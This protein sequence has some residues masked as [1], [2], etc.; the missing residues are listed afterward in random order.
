[1]GTGL[2][3]L[4]CHFMCI[5]LFVVLLYYS[6]D[7][8]RVYSDIP[9]FI[10]ELVICVLFLK[11]VLLEVCQFYWSYQM[12]YWY[13]LL[14]FCFQFHWFSAPV[15]IIFFLLIT[16]VYFALLFWDFWGLHMC[17]CVSAWVGVSFCGIFYIDNNHI[18]N[19]NIF[20]DWLESFP[21]F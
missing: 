19:N 11:L 17:V 18:E 7:V 3:H 13:S 10:T 16:L 21:L 15:F 8:S 2:F 12:F 4:S 14:F 1:M 20:L 9:C 5:V 6:F